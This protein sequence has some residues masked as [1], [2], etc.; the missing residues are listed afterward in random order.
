MESVFSLCFSTIRL[1]GLSVTVEA[2][3]E[4]AVVAAV[5]AACLR[6]PKFAIYNIAIIWIVVSCLQLGHINVPSSFLVIFQSQPMC[7]QQSWMSAEQP[8]RYKHHWLI[9]NTEED[10]SHVDMFMYLIAIQKTIILSI[11]QV[12]G[13]HKP[14]NTSCWYQLLVVNRQ[15]GFLNFLWGV[16]VLHH[17][18]HS[19]QP[20]IYISLFSKNE[21]TTLLII[22]LGWYS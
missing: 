9:S 8:I 18:R 6:T 21:S 11:K 22:S 14:K 5:V 12:S 7:L 3:V 17:I 13:T 16:I 19:G 1:S 10:N 2:A 15:R 4:A 20:N